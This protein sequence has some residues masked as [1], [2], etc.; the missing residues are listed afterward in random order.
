MYLPSHR[1][2]YQVSGPYWIYLLALFLVLSCCKTPD[3]PLE[4]ISGYPTEI[5]AIIH[6]S[7]AIEGC[8]AGS[9]PAYGLDLYSWEALHRGSEAGA[10]VVPYA[11]FWSP[12]FQHVNDWD[13][14]GPTAM[15]RMPKNAPSLSA[16]HV[17]VLKNWIMEGARNDK[18]KPYW[19]RAE[20]RSTDKLFALCAGSDQ[21]AVLDVQTG[22]LMRY[23]AVG[24]D[25]H[26]LEAPHYLAISPDQQY[27]YLTL[28]SSG[29]GGSP[30]VEKYRTSD[31]APAGRVKV[32]PDPAIIQIS[33]DGKRAVVSHFNNYHA[34]KLSLI[35]TER[36]V[37]LDALTGSEGI[38]A[39]PHGLAVTADF[40]AVYVVAATGNYF[41]R[42]GIQGDRLIWDPEQRYLLD[43]SEAVATT[44]INY[45]PYQC[46]LWE[47]AG[48]LF[49]S[50]NATH[51][52][53]VFDLKDHQLLKKIPVGHF[54]RLMA[55]DTAAHRL[56]VICAYEEHTAIQGERL[57][58][59]S[60]IDLDR[61]EEIK[62]IYEVGHQPH[63]IALDAK[64]GRLYVTSENIGGKDALRR[65]KRGLGGWPGKLHS[66][67]IASLEVIEGQGL[68]IALY[69]NAC[70]LTR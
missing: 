19:L 22:L 58:C 30:I 27:L 50:Q 61:L 35:D 70:A 65:H 17:Q 2:I 4:D 11:P 24:Q 29:R 3:E 18:G 23:M 37:V 31:Y 10:A 7:C 45:K 20:A 49:I 41:M 57:G 54:P 63:G 38:L 40:D 14:L 32:G 6:T 48:Y 47:A 28:L 33:A 1:M 13:S 42:I 9:A 67:D 12:L 62:R 25:P 68:E 55:C 43:P 69:P 52:V 53:R 8:H 51:D 34:T 36:M 26:R 39:S 21:V 46:I 66:I 44:S 56:Y 60:V 64:R 16:N 15:P 5:K 59:V